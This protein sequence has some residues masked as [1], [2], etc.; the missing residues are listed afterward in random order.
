MNV[1]SDLQS[2]EETGYVLIENL[3]DEG[4]LSRLREGLAPFLARHRGRNRFEGAKT[5]RIYTLVAMG[6]PFAA[7]VEHKRILAL[8]DRLLMPNYL[9]TA[10]QAIHIHPGEAAQPLHFDDSFYPLP[11]PR[12]PVSVSTI[13][14][15]DPFTEENGAT[16]LI[17]GSHCWGDELPVEAAGPQDFNPE[18]GYR[19]AG[20]RA[21]WRNRDD[22]K[23]VAAVMPAGSV[24]IFPGTLWHGGGANR[25]G[26]SR[27]A[28]SNQY[29]QPWARQQENYTLAV[30]PE[31]AARLSPR[32]RA[33]LGYSIHPPFMGHIGGRHPEKHLLARSS[34]T[35]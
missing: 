1:A 35:A 30:P 32:V 33:L 24:L 4:E 31:T 14:A 8:L 21:G 23:I 12:P 18:T 22:Y 11:R 27:L 29:C 34:A 2:I 19:E 7:L 20:Q 25:S 26:A 6:E 17:P 5:E 10:S 9:L 3:L 13:W 28:I 16:V 15:V